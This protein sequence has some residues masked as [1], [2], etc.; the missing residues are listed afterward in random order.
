MKIDLQ[1]SH[2]K[3]WLVTREKIS[4]LNSRSD[5]SKLDYARQGL[6]STSNI[7]SML[8]KVSLNIKFRDD[9]LFF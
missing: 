1:A 5:I 9:I 3:R 2:R 7:S 4:S 8:Y 6:R